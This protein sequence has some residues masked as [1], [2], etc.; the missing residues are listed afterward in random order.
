MSNE[1]PNV[2]GMQSDIKLLQQ[3]QVH[4]E[5]AVIGMSAKL[6]G[7]VDALT[8]LVRLTEKHNALSKRV[9]SLE[10]S[11]DQRET[12]VSTG[13][14]YM[15][16]ATII[17]PALVGGLVWLGNQVIDIKGKISKHESHYETHR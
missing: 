11:S 3:G 16:A 13:K 9:D 8:T 2:H 4:I 17:L 12:V 5:R 6:D 1:E 10:R 7:V 15:F 14:A